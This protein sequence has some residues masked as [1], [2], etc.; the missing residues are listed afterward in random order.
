MIEKIKR[1]YNTYYTLKL[2]LNKSDNP[3][4]E[5]IKKSNRWFTNIQMVDPAIVVYGFKDPKP[6][7][8]LVKPSDIPNGFVAFKEFFLVQIQVTKKA[9]HGR[10][11]GLGMH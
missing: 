3:M 1:P 4:E 9:L 6:T 2:K 10:K 7:Y 11:S 5:L 8:G